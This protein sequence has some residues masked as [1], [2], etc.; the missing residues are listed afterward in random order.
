MGTMR[1]RDLAQHP[2]L[3]W[4]GRAT[5][6]LAATVLVSIRLVSPLGLPR[7]TMLGP[8]AAA[9]AGWYVSGP[10][11]ARSRV[12][13]GV[14]LLALIPLPAAVLVSLLAFAVYDGRVF[15]A[16]GLLLARSLLG[17][18]LTARDPDRLLHLHV[19]G[20]TGSGKSTTALFPWIRQDLE[21]GVGLTVIEPKGD[22]NGA[23][24]REALTWGRTVVPFDPLAPACPHVNLLAGDAAAAAEALALALDQV[25]PGAHP[26]YRTLSRVVLVHAVKL[27]KAVYGDDA[28]LEMVERAVHEASFRDRL[29]K[30][31]RD[32]AIDQFF[33]QEFGALPPGRQLDLEIGL[34]NRLRSLRMHPGAARVLAPPFDFTFDEVIQS[35]LVLLATLSP[36]ELGIGAR[37][38]GVLFWHL[39][40]QA[41]YRAGPTGQLRH[42]LY[43][44]EFHQYVSP[45]LADVLAM[46]RGYGVSL[47]L[48]HQ[49]LAQLSP[50]LQAAVLANART[51]LV[52]GGTAAADL[53]RLEREAVPSP[54]PEARYLPRGR[55]VLIPTVDGRQRPPRLVRLAAPPAPE[56]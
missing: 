26:F 35:R 29:R 48:A 54:F 23:G 37:S 25:E 16:R 13:A 47:V 53:R 38:L 42:V 36:A 22:L 45:D 21:R 3:H 44:D 34:L 11:R 19:L 20:P 14:V 27:V 41:A 51:R 39:F 33:E 18:P 5:L 50:E 17:Y 2:V 56:P 7:L 46:I 15:R 49:D 55:A 24:R 10:F 6:W 12:P 31:A 1:L 4:A 52:L 9:A 8:L 28:G 40:V 32:P 30:A 43:L